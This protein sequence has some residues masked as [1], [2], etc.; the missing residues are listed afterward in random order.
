M[1]STHR[2]LI[3]FGAESASPRRSLEA[4][5]PFGVILIPTNRERPAKQRS[6]LALTIAPAARWLLPSHQWIL[7]LCHLF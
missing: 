6:M 4:R 7:Y 5:A 1:P 2:M 3:T